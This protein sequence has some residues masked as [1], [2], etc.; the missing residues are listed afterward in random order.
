MVKGK[1]TNMAT[2]KNQLMATTTTAYIQSIKK[3]T[4]DPR[5]MAIEAVKGWQ[6]GARLTNRLAY[7]A[8]FH[9]M[10]TK[11]SFPKKQKTI[12][13][14][15]LCNDVLKISPSKGYYLIQFYKRCESNNHLLDDDFALI[16]FH[17]RYRDP[18]QTQQDNDKKDAN[19]K[20]QPRDKQDDKDEEPQDDEK[21][22]Q[23]EPAN[24]VEPEYGPINATITIHCNKELAD[25]LAII[26]EDRDTRVIISIQDYNQNAFQVSRK[27]T[28]PVPNHLRIV[29]PPPTD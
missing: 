18:R 16:E 7:R 21:E 19:K 12:E 27:Q 2:K 28:Q 6:M 1:G 26:A 4:K 3:E 9:L 10:R 29:S 25:E 20:N 15:V 8:G 11:D 5:T 17:K 13:F 14:D 24:I 22:N 23:D